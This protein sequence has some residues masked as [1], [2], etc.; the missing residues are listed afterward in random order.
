MKE[1]HR[2]G[3]SVPEPGPADFMV[4]RDLKWEAPWI[5]VR[6]WVELP[7]WLMVDNSTLVIE[8]Q[9][10]EFPVD[11]HDDYFELHVGEFA[12][13]RQNV[14][15][16]GPRKKL[17]DLSGAIQQMRKTHPDTPLIWRKCKTI[18]KV[19]TRC[20]EEVWKRAS[21]D[22]TARPT[23]LQMY[24]VELCRAHIPVINRLV[25]DYRLATYDYFPYEVSPWDVSSWVVERE[26][27][28]IS[29]TL[30]SYREWDEK[31]LFLGQMHDVIAG[32]AKEPP[33]AYQT[34]PIHRS[35]QTAWDAAWSR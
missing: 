12:D 3:S 11:V 31:P 8:V 20:N 2:I 29:V 5:D 14:V 27:Q 4:G 15:Y 34:D 28:A 32:A 18:L 17:E 24:L 25:Q 22:A 9:G 10:H 33:K 1:R 23:G 35:S 13:S 7:F 16:R 26:R 6:L 19:A 21:G 30:V